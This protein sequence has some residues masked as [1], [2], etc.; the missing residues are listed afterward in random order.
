VDGIGTDGD[1]RRERVMN[2]GDPMMLNT[3]LDR[4]VTLE[5]RGARTV[6]V[7][8]Y[9]NG[10]AAAVHAVMVALWTSPLGGDRVPPAVP[11]PLALDGDCVVMEHVNGRELGTRRDGWSGDHLPEL[12][13]LVADFNLCGVSVDRRRS[14]AAL[15]RSLARKHTELA[16]GHAPSALVVEFDAALRA[17]ERAAPSDEQLVLSHG[18]C[19][20]RNVLVSDAGLRLIDFDR[21]A[22]SGPGRDVAYLGAW[23]WAS[24]LLNEG[25]VSWQLADE[26]VDRYCDEV[27]GRHAGVSSTIIDTVRRTTAFHRAAALL[28][29]AHGWS[30][31]AAR[32]DLAVEVCVEAQRQPI[33]P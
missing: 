14:G 7:K 13:T 26:L 32:P 20:P 30:A 10:G 33:D 25:R 17:I 19:S 1:Q 29:I 15:V 9:N 5:T 4:P 2:V 6:V 12:V 3:H 22:M 27:R 24:L 8:R 16:T 31:M 28:R 21:L 11:E 18:D 23:V